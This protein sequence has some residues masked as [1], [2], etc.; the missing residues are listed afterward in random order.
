MR[1]PIKGHYGTLTSHITELDEDHYKLEFELPYFRVGGDVDKLMYVDPSGGPFM[2]IRD[3]LSRFHKDL[4][5][6]KIAK[7]L[8]GEDGFVFELEPQ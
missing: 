1:T 5:D 7:I 2:H 6:R 3:P 8:N 4:P